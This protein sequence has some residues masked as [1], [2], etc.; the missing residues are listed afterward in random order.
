M[1]FKNIFSWN[2]LVSGFA[3]NGRGELA[4]EAFD[5][6]MEER[7]KPDGVTF[8]AL[9][10]AC[11]HQ[12]FVDE[13]RR[14]FDEMTRAYRVR[15][16][17]EHYGCM[18]DILARAGFLEEAHGLVRTMPVDPDAV[19][20]RAL[21]AGCRIHG[22]TQLG[23]FVIRK[24]LELEPNNGENYVLLSNMLARGQKWSEVGE[25]RNV[26]SRK[27]IGKVPGCSS[28]EI[29]N[30]VYEFVVMSRSDEGGMQEIFA[31]LDDMN[32]K[33]KAAGYAAETDMVSYDLEEEEKE[34]SLMHHSE[35]LALA[36]GLLK[37]PHGS[38]IRIVKN[39][40][41]CRDCHTFFKLV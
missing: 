17:I 18:V 36:F 31:M 41:V 27:G 24:L 38:V 9:L 28:I 7:I 19:I 37:T 40:R 35:K 14:I 11:C 5:E 2:V 39:L 30:M 34:G 16:K 23:E 22:N 15:P 3:M 1:N 4:M 32:T 20:W 33:L 12:G 26:M 10:C 8:L 25:V 21:L 13:G 6:M 29:D